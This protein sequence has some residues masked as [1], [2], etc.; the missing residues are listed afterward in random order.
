LAL[1]QARYCC[2]G[3]YDSLSNYDGVSSMECADDISRCITTSIFSRTALSCGVATS[4]DGCDDDYCNCPAG[5]RSSGDIT[6]EFREMKKIMFPIMGVIFGILWVLLAFFGARLPVKI[7]LLIVGLI[8]GVLGIFLIFLPVTTFLGLFYIAIG[9]FAIAVSRHYWGGNNGIYLLLALMV[10]VFLLTGGLTFV[11][12]DFGRG[13]DYF[14]RVAGYIP[15]CDRDMN[16]DRDGD[17]DVS[18][19]CGNYALFV[20]FCV[21]LLFLIQPIGMLA[22]AFLREGHHTDTTVVS[23]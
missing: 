14:G 5:Y 11:A 15:I 3:S 8:N 7:L 21:F 2:T 16:I 4:T 10:I 12:F 9:A 23:V 1:A 22:A 13:S 19:R 20:G 17:D 6:S 18:T